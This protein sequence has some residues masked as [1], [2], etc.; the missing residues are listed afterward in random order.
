MWYQVDG[1]NIVDGPMRLPNLW[2]YNGVQYPVAELERKGYAADL[3]DIGWLPE[4]IVETPRP[5]TKKVTG[6]NRVVANGVVRVVEIIGN[7]TQ[8]EIDADIA[9]TNELEDRNSVGLDAEIKA[10][11]AKRP[12]QINT[13]I[14][15]NVT[16]LASAKTLLKAYGRV[17]SVI[18]RNLVD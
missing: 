2:L 6:Y 11:L 10:W 17:L 3:P 16:D 5:I 14:D 18:A 13:Y 8:A 4:V 15:N 7:K 9:R 12:S 1:N